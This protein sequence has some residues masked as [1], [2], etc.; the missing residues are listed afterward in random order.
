MTPQPVTNPYEMSARQTKAHA[1]AD[2]LFDNDFPATDVAFITDLQ[3]EALA[4]QAGCQPPH[5]QDTI[6]LVTEILTK[7]QN[8]RAAAKRNVDKLFAES[9]REDPFEGIPDPSSSPAPGEAVYR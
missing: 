3:W 4:K 2:L 9:E 7:R 8:A 6:D 5:S 1:L